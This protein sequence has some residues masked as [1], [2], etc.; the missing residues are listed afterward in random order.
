MEG[1]NL[2]KVHDHN[3]FCRV[4]EDKDEDDLVY[5]QPEQLPAWCPDSCLNDPLQLCHLQ[6][7]QGWCHNHCQDFICP[8]P[9]FFQVDFEDQTSPYYCKRNVFVIC[10]VLSV[11]MVVSGIIAVFFYCWL[12]IVDTRRPSNRIDNPC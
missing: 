8:V 5:C 2:S 3:M 9:T 1:C 10:F 12:K 7:G 4:S 6:H 11:I